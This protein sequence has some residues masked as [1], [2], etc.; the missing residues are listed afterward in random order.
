MACCRPT[1]PT[2]HPNS[3]GQL[4]RSTLGGQQPEPLQALLPSWAPGLGQNQVPGNRCWGKQAGW[5]LCEGLPSSCP[6][7]DPWT[8]SQSCSPQLCCPP[9]GLQPQGMCCPTGTPSPHFKAP[10]R[11]GTDCS[12]HHKSALL[13]WGPP[14]SRAHAQG[15]RPGF[16]GC[17]GLPLPLR[18]SAS[19]EPHHTAAH[20]QRWAGPAAQTLRPRGFCLHTHTLLPQLEPLPSPHA[21]TGCVPAPG[22]TFPLRVWPPR[23]PRATWR[24]TL[25]TRVP[26]Q[27]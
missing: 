26:P 2:L 9:L 23:R 17:L 20:T 1:S 15:F 11:D 14:S 4:E 22:V 3:S 6:R 10:V 27:L 25:A 13:C 18:I 7:T 5:G 12:F 16:W 19:P 21:H 24:A 8:L